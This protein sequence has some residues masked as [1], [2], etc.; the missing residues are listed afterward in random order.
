MGRDKFTI[1][2]VAFCREVRGCS[3]PLGAVRGAEHCCAGGLRWVRAAQ[4]Q[5]APKGFFPLCPSPR[6]HSGSLSANP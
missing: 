5:T 1:S 2:M 3:F 4:P 6:L